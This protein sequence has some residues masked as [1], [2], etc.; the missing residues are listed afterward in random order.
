[1]KGTDTLQITKIITDD[2]MRETRMHGTPDFPFQ[3]YLDDIHKFENHYVEWHWHTE[4]EFVI[5]TSGIIDCLIGTERI[6]LSPGDGL[7][8]NSKIIHRFESAAGGLMPNILFLPEFLS[9]ST[10]A[11][12][13]ENIAPVLQS[14]LPYCILRQDDSANT[15]LLEKLF[16]ICRIADTRTPDKLNILLAVLSLWQD[17]Y[18]TYTNRFGISGNPKNMLLQS[19]MRCMMQYIFEHYKEKITLTDI[20]SAASISKSEALRCFHIALATTP[21][22]YLVDYR[23]A[24]AR[25]LLLTTDDTVTQ[26]ALS[27]GI[28]NISYFVRTFKKKYGVTPKTYQMKNK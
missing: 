10:T 18:C 14:D 24:C 11:I 19:R 15:A 5:V 23:L 13:R 7:F 12:Y 8:I 17:F 28:E 4:F 26:A 3:Y 21:I 6:T 25:E 27:V 20:A 9:A 16:Y 22:N 2:K 1:M